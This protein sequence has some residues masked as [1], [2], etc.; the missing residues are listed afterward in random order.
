MAKTTGK[1]PPVG[2]GRRAARP[3]AVREPAPAG[4]RARKNMRLDQRLLD[5]ARRVLG[6]ADETEAVTIA[7]RRV[8]NNARVAAGIGAIAGRGEIDERRIED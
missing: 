5:Q 4:P 6:A 1:R 8:V 2:A 3:T 7:L